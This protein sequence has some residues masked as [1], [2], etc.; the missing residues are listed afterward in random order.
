MDGV[1]KRIV[2]NERGLKVGEDHHNAKLTDHEVEL[3]LTLHDDGV[4][5]KRLGEIFGISKSGARKI[6]KG[7]CRCQVA[8]RYRTVEVHV[9]VK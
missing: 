8:I 7:Q 6:C 4:G 3:L 9:P 1:K 5:Y 2:V